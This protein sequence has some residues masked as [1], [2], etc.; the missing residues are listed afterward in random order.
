MGFFKLCSQS[1]GK[2][3]I[4]FVFGLCDFSYPYSCVLNIEFALFFSNVLLS[5]VS[6]HTPYK[7]ECPE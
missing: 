7:R 3:E 1:K 6:T 4:K 2:L 5:D